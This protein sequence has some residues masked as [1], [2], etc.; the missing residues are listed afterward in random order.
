MVAEAPWQDA[1]LRPLAVVNANASGDARAA[2]LLEAL[3]AAAPDVEVV[4]TADPGALA[5]TLAEA[6]G[7]RTILV[8]GD[9]TLHAAVNA[10]V[11]LPELALL[12]AGRANNVARA[13]GV[14]SDPG[15]AARLALAA[16]ARP[17]DVLRA[18]TAAGRVL[19][20]VEGVSA[21]FQAQA[22]AGYAGVNSGDL[23]AGAR[24]L[25]RAFAGYRP[26]RV[27]IDADGAVAVAGEVAQVFFSNLPFFG[28][29]F[30]VDPIAHP[31]DGRFEVVVA[32]ARSRREL[33][34]LL[35]AARRGSHLDRP[36]VTVRRAR[37]AVLRGELALA[38]DAEPLGSGDVEVSLEPGAVRVAAPA[39]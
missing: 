37:H 14:P 34:G 5:G 8:G 38:G 18:R 9:G 7:R 35:V 10:G 26:G 23:A 11:A 25:A 22:R 2:V 30:R 16:P 17:L 20:C 4:A 19:R 36:G 13:L 29:G 12:P 28:F 27:E 32:R 24:A 31:R 21:G 6:G 1:R 3:R 39:G 33:A 15:A